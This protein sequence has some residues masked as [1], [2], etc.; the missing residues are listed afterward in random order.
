MAGWPVRLVAVLW[1]RLGGGMQWRVLWLT[2]PKFMVSVCGV[3]RDEHGRV[4]LL[5]H[6]FW[7]EGSWGLPGGYA[8]GAERLEDA[9]ARELR[10]E[11]G[12]RIDEQRLLRVNSGYRLRVEVVFTARLAGG[13]LRLDSRE[14]LAAQLFA[15]DALPPGLLRSHREL[16]AQA[17][18]ASR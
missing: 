2:Q 13:D 4:L 16:I 6:R 12:W 7:P 8:H 5:R 14:V 3:V 18:A 17:V 10:E 11:T 1:H 9:L 15:P